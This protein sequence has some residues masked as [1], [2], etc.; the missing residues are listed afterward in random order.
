M[1]PSFDYQR[2]TLKINA[3]KSLKVAMQSVDGALCEEWPCSIR[4]KI[5]SLTVSL[6][7]ERRN[8]LVSAWLG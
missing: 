4:N 5:A 2:L 7:N 8:L 3:W 1:S 6:G